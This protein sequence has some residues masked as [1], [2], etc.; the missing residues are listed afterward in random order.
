[1]IIHDDKPV[2]AQ[3]TLI[4]FLLC[5]GAASLLSWIPLFSYA[6]HWWH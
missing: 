4:I 5:A 2:L 1:M 3:A 6:W